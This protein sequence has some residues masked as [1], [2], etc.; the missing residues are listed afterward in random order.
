MIQKD[1]IFGSLVAGAIGD[2]LGYAVEFLSYNSIL[3]TYGSCGITC[4]ELTER[5]ARF[6]DDTQMTLFTANGLL[7]GIIRNRISQ[8][9]TPLIDY[10]SNA[11]VDWYKTQFRQDCMIPEN[12]RTCW[13]SSLSQLYTLRAPGNTCL[14]AIQ[15]SINGLKIDNNSKG[16]GGIM[17]VAPVA[18]AFDKCTS[19]DAKAIFTYQ[20][21]IDQLACEIAKLTHLH[22]LGFLPASL[23]VHLLH[24]LIHTSDT[25]TSEW[26]KNTVFEGLW[27]L[28]NM[29]DSAYGIPY[30]QLYR[31]EL[32]ELNIL[33]L[34]TFRLAETSTCDTEAI[35]QLG[36]GWTADEAWY[37]ALYCTIRHLDSI[38]DAIIAAVN[39]DGDSDSTGA[40]TGNIMGAIHGYQTILKHNLFC[41]PE[42]KLTETLELSDIILAIADDLYATCINDPNN[43]ITESEN[44]RLIER[45]L[46]IKPYGIKEVQ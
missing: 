41:P 39:H 46:K 31:N 9:K 18:L 5:I 10:V 22:P 20:S 28:D 43:P 45:Y 8:R 32:D 21:K 1:K 13:L 33:T 3:E 38:H 17:R 2:A 37:I 27:Y 24:K 7:N 6:S 14:N 44:N 19:S 40:I 23:M 12:E 26:I 15:Q 29:T 11:Y 42:Y 25:I 34:R 16:C 35:K 36:Q 4:Y 30:S